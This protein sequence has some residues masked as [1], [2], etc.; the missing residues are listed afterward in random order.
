LGL[1]ACR[2]N[3]LNK[4]VPHPRYHRRPPTEQWNPLRNLAM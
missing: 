3:G 1:N 4:A 2:R